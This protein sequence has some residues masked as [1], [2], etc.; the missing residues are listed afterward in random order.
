MQEKWNLRSDRHIDGNTLDCLVTLY[1]PPPSTP[2]NPFTL[3]HKNVQPRRMQRNCEARHHACN[4]NAY[5]CVWS[6]A[7]LA[8]SLGWSVHRRDCKARPANRA[9]SYRKA[10]G[11]FRCFGTDFWRTSLIARK[12]FQP[13]SRAMDIGHFPVE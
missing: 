7:L 12:L 9:A 2:S 11:E 8:R 6:V 1:V 3:V 13:T 5:A 4:G 10:Q